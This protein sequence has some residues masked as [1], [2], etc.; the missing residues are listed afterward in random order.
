MTGVLASFEER[1]LKQS[2]SHVILL[3]FREGVGF[4]PALFFEVAEGVLAGGF[5]GI[6]SE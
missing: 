5:V 4:G 2:H 1:P 3:V 6:C